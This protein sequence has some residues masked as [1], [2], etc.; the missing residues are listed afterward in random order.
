[1]TL[2]EVLM[3]VAVLLLL[4]AVF[5]P[6]LN[7]GPARAPRIQCVNN[8]K[9]IALADRVWEGDH[10]DTYPLFVPGTNGGTMDFT[11]GPN[12]W[13]HFQVMSNEISTPK[14]LFCPAE[15]DP[16]RFVATN[17]IHLNN[18]NLSFFV[19]L[20]PNDTNPALILAGDHNITNGAP[21][22]NA[23][24]GLTTNQRAGWTAE[25]HHEVGNVALADGSVQEVSSAGLQTAV[26]N[27]GV[28]T[29]WLQM[30]I[31]GP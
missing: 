18:S 24:L 12:A 15:T 11:S 28:A 16:G 19:G 25:V 1:M 10:G 7:H 17:F 4:A 13:R 3:V 27:S 9:Q 5:L 20:V 21:V 31:L 26:A 14:I 30:P 8:L 23:L 6:T 2:I 22:R 29:N